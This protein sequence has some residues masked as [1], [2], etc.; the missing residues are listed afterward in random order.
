MPNTHTSWLTNFV[1]TVK[2][3]MCH[4]CGT[5]FFQISKF[6]SASMFNNKPIIRLEHRSQTSISLFPISKIK[7]KKNYD[8]P[9]SSNVGHGRSWKP[10][11]SPTSTI[12]QG[13]RRLGVSQAA[14]TQLFHGIPQLFSSQVRSLRLGTLGTFAGVAGWDIM[15]PWSPG[16]LEMKLWKKQFL[17][18]DL[19]VWN[20]GKHIVF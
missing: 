15:V 19:A 7:I 20:C 17:Y 4:F 18:R 12:P 2:S 1:V 16:I 11:I 8:T 6:P 13:T 3:P 9:I 5:V 14:R 10:S